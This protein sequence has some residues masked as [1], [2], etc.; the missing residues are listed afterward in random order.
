MV[1]LRLIAAAAGA[2]DALGVRMTQ[3]LL[4]DRTAPIVPALEAAGFA[5][6]VDLEYLSW[7]AAP[8]PPPATLQ[9]EPFQE[10]Q[11]DRLARLIEA[12]YAETKDCPALNGTRPMSEVLAGYR[13]TGRYRP[14]NWQFARVGG[15]DVGV[16]LLADHAAAQY[17]ELMYMGLAPPVRGRGWGGD[18]V[19]HAQRMA[20]NA[21]AERLLLAVDAAN[22]P[23]LAMYRD[24][25][26]TPWDQRTVYVR[27][28]GAARD[29]E[30]CE[31]SPRA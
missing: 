24:A 20:R 22:A 6:L 9:F 14:E 5:H 3:A 12:T 8:V 10:P 27:F 7:E 16:L 30:L 23:A 25:G 15:E 28:G 18:I 19:R 13:G 17:W 31:N 11:S 26:F 29:N 2:L 4:A 21:G 1:A